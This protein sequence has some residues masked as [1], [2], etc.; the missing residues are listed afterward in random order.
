[1]KK[2]V[3]PISVITF[4]LLS[5]VILLSVI[6][7]WCFRISFYESEYN[8]SETASEIGMSDEDLLNSTQTLLDYLRD[9]R[10]DIEVEADVQGTTVYVFNDRETAHMIDVKNLYQTA[11]TVRNAAA[12]VSV[13]GLVIML[14]FDKKN[15]RENCK[16]GYLYGVSL[17]IL[18]LAFVGIWAVSDFSGFWTAFHEF[19][20]SNDLWLLDPNTSI[21][22]NMFPSSFFSDL[23]YRIIFCIIA[24][25]GIIALLIYFPWRKLYDKRRAV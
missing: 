2:A 21:M 14:L 13:I 3:K 4:F 5:A 24:V 11:I 10:D 20:F 9:D 8:N 7:F 15:F 23:V 6:D 22:I 18:L 19:F 16:T 1:M 17:M 12:V 25:L